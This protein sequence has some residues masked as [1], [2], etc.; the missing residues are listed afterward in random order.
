VVAIPDA[1]KGEALLLITNAPE[2]TRS[3]LL[4]AAQR[5]GINNLLIPQK[6]HVVEAIPLLGS[7]KVDYGAAQRVA[8]H[9]LASQTANGN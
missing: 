6:V 7:G 8:H 2:I 4:T 5:L 3:W 9:W 1:K